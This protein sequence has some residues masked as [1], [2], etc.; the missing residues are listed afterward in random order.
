MNK[1]ISN[2][3]KI[4]KDVNELSFK[5]NQELYECC[6][7]DR[8]SDGSSLYIESRGINSGCVIII[9][10]EHHLKELK[11][12]IDATLNI[13]KMLKLKKKGVIK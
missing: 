10:T 5:L 13:R 7:I 8:D 2:K 6:R 9:C 11:R 1:K 3:D 12:K 4:F